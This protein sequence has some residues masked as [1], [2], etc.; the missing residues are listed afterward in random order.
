MA[1]GMLCVE[2]EKLAVRATAFL[3]VLTIADIRAMTGLVAQAAAQL[4]HA[5]PARPRSP[6]VSAFHNYAS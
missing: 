6:R 3:D 4:A 2:A 1:V 5:V